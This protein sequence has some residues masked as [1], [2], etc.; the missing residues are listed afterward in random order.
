MHLHSKLSIFFDISLSRFLPS[1]G[2]RRL[3]PFLLCPCD[4]PGVVNKQIL[5][6]FCYQAGKVEKES[7]PRKVMKKWNLGKE[8]EVWRIESCSKAC[9]NHIGN[10]P[11]YILPFFT[12]I[13]RRKGKYAVYKYKKI[14]V[15]E[16]QRPLSQS[17]PLCIAGEKLLVQKREC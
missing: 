8:R 1:S 14:K 3:F 7:M 4:A 6:S 2:Q 9:T 13:K 17:V 16:R 10:R 5:T 11:K 12:I 15:F